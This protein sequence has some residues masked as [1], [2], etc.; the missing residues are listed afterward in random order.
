[1]GAGRMNRSRQPS[2]RPPLGVWFRAVRAF[3]FTASL[4]PVLLGAALA[5]GAPA[6]RWELVPLVALG[7]VLVHA[8]TNLI[9][10]AADYQR[11]VD[12]PGTHGGSGVLV[13][14]LLVPGQVFRFGL[15]LL[16]AGSVVGIVLVCVR[17]WPVLGLG[18]LGVLG[19]FFYGGR[20][21][22]YKYVGLGDL[23]VFL[24]MGPLI[25]VG[26]HFTLTG[27]FSLRALL[28]SLPV[29]CLV[30]AILHSNNFRDI[31]QDSSCGVRTLANLLGPRF[32]KVEYFLLVIA[33]YALATVLTVRQL[34]PPWALL[35]VLVLPTAVK[36]LATVLRASPERAAEFASI[37]VETAKLHMAFGVLL[38]VGVALG[39][40]L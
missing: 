4:T 36:N 31:V 33:A 23:M 6:V 13:K 5:V 19:G 21:F 9:S 2:G 15:L 7:C 38:S 34:L 32:A 14:G 17:G 28:A 37:D 16:S 18:L 8:G 22:G 1:M 27:G 24:L 3:S 10:D 39:A 26:T 35:V 29:A 20:S 30:T 25:V 11:G 40:I 12:R